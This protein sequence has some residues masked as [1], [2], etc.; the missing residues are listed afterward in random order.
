MHGV[1]SRGTLRCF[2]SVPRLGDPP[3]I[4]R[5][6][7]VHSCQLAEI[8]V[9]VK[10][11]RVKWLVRSWASLPWR[12][13]GCQ[14]QVRAPGKTNSWIFHDAQPTCR[15]DLAVDILASQHSA[16][17]SSSIPEIPLC[18]AIFAGDAF[19]P[20]LD[21]DK[22]NPLARVKDEGAFDRGGSNAERNKEQKNATL[23]NTHL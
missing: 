18:D 4:I 1:K 16:A 6:G 23:L 13:M 2:A 20:V 10:H 12:R 14:S 8:P 9:R 22:T 3:P 7:F 19:L 5:I 15:Q 11:D 17:C 21:L